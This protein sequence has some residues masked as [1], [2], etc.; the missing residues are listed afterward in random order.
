M[1]ARELQSSQTLRKEEFLSDADLLPTQFGLERS[2]S[3]GY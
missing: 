1:V 2:R 3:F